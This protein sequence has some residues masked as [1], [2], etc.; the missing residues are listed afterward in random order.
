[1]G[2]ILYEKKDRVAYITLNRP[3]K[4]NAVS[5]EL[6][7]ALLEALVDFDR[8]EHLWVAVITGAGERAFSAGADL[9]DAAHLVAP[10]EWEAEFV[11]RLDGVKKPVIAAVNGYCLGVGFA[12]ALTCDL[13]VASETALF[14]TPDQKRN[15]VDCYASLM[16]PAIVSRAVAMEILFTGEMINA[17]EAYRAGLVNRVAAPAALITETERL[18]Q[19]VL[20][21]GPLALQACKELV[22]RGRT[23]A[24][25]EG[26]SLF[27][28]E[29]LRVLS[30]EDTVE[31]VSAFLEKRA[32]V[33]KG[34]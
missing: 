23:A 26:L 25:D 24:L 27:K 11:R 34:R 1:M 4:L 17:R 10:H 5:R 20:Q 28:K 3:E 14:G 9:S 6:A 22:K 30:S 18:V 29:A 7:A 32:P 15:T 19:Q 31:G 13:R 12:V 21:N 8:D 33:W 2:V 16:L